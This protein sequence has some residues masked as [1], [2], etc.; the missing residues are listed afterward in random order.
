MARS[1]VE[2]VKDLLG[3]LTNADAIKSLV[4]PDATYVSLNYED[5]DLKR[6]LPWAGTSQGPQAFIDTFSRVF[7]FWDSENF[8]VKELFGSG[9]NVAVFGSFTFKDVGQGRHDTVLHLGQSE[10]RQNRLLAVH[11][12]QL[13]DCRI[14]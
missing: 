14:V 2:M 12:R 10:G 11:K 8:E 3:S 9:D 7:R 6:I 13:R 5:K 1:P 4:A